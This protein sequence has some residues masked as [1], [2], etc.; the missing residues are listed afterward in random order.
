M[1]ILRLDRG[2]RAGVPTVVCLGFF[3]G[4]H[5]GHARLIGCAREVADAGALSVC[6][7]TFDAMPQRVL[8][9][10]ADVLELTP[11]PQKAALL[12][13]M[14]VDILAVSPFDEA[15]Q[16]MTAQAFFRDILLDSLCA[17]HIV[18]GFHH[19]FGFHGEGDAQLLRTLCERAGVGLDVIQPVTL[20]GGELISSTAIRDAIRAGNLDRAG[21]MLGRPATLTGMEGSISLYNIAN[22][23]GRNDRPLEDREEST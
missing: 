23:K 6:V 14:G 22:N 18:A 13:D 15:T 1:N 3:D 9:P 17:R 2:E 12:A 21:R 19:H 4:V 8:H 20:P 11:L 16:R 5:L 7:H 10:R